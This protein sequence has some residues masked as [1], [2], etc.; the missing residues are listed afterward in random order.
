MIATTLALLTGSAVAGVNQKR[1]PSSE[2]V[3][4]LD[5]QPRRLPRQR[6][7][8]TTSALQDQQVEPLEQASLQASEP[9][10]GKDSPKPPGKR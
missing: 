7:L 4:P 1:G 2:S 8:E 5:E 9:E 3:L 10:E 6:S